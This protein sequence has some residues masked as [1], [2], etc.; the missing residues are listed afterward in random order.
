MT[1]AESN[2]KTAERYMVCTEVGGWS[3]RDRHAPLC[4]REGEMGVCPTLAKA[5]EIRDALNAQANSSTPSNSS[6]A[7]APKE[8][9]TLEK[10]ANQI[11]DLQLAVA[12]L[13]QQ[14]ADDT[15]ATIAAAADDMKHRRDCIQRG[16]ELQAQVAALKA[17][18]DGA[19][20]SRHNI[21][22]R[23]RTVEKPRTIPIEVGEDGPIC[24]DVIGQP[25]P[26]ADAAVETQEAYYVPKDADG[27]LHP[28]IESDVVHA[29]IV[30]AMQRTDIPGY[31]EANVFNELAIAA[32]DAAKKD[33]EEEQPQPKAA[34]VEEAIEQIEVDFGGCVFSD[35]VRQHCRDLADAVRAADA[36]GKVKYWGV[37]GKDKEW[38]DFVGRHHEGRKGWKHPDGEYLKHRAHLWPDRGGA[39]AHTGPG[40]TLVPL[41]VEEVVA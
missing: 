34:A 28:T 27:N 7:D 24:V 22:G 8:A 33:G 19:H 4:M 39:Y 23:L 15:S 9:T 3:V 36:E 2:D 21:R 35:E 25:Q 31:N 17:R 18:A 20:E 11:M 29:A 12:G 32:W 37:R 14:R 10:Q 38:E 26:K 5:Q 13:K 30:K 1:K 16:V 40:D 6:D 41:V